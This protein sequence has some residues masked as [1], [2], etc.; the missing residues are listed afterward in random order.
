MVRCNIITYVLFTKKDS[1]KLGIMYNKRHE[2]G[3]N[4]NKI[5]DYAGE[6]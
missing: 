6:G 5:Y 3:K 1:F 2:N 4:I